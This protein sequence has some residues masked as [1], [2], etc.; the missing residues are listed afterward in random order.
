MNPKPAGT[1]ERK[2]AITIAAPHQSKPQRTAWRPS[3]GVL[4]AV[5]DRF[6]QSSDVPIPTELASEILSILPFPDII[7]QLNGGGGTTAPEEMPLL[8]VEVRIDEARLYGRYATLCSG[9]VLSP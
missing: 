2:R 6:R 5:R 4:S 9:A 1:R 3:A 8:N 7:A